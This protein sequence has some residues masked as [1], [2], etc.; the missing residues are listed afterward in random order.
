[1]FGLPRPSTPPAPL[2]LAAFGP[3][4]IVCADLAHAARLLLRNDPRSRIAQLA[5]LDHTR[6]AL[7]LRAMADNLLLRPA[8]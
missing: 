5:R 2:P 1:M 6:A 4:A 8:P 3:A 7:R